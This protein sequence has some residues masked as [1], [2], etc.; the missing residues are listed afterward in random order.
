[1]RNEKGSDDDLDP[2]EPEIL[3]LLRDLTPEEKA[4]FS[5]KYKKFENEFKKLE[6]QKSALSK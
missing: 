2:N 6:E 1:M 3:K 5:E 4:K